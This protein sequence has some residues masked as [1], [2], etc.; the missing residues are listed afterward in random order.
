MDRKKYRKLL[1]F[2]SKSL[3]TIL[4]SLISVVMVLPFVWMIS[5]SLKQ[6]SEVFNYPI[7]WIPKKFDFSYHVAVWTG[8]DSLVRYYLNS[9]K[10][11]V[12]PVIAGLVICSMAAYSFSKLEY[13]GRNFIFMLYMAMLMIPQQILFVPKFLLFVPLGIYN[14]HWALILPHC[15]SITS[16]FLMRQS[17]MSIPNEFSEAAIIDGASHFRIWSQIIMPLS[18]PIIATVSILTFTWY[19]N[20][21]Q[22]ALIFISSKKLYTVPLILSRYVLDDRIDYSAMMAA[23]FAGIVPLILVFLFFQKFIIQGVASSGVKG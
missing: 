13:K 6:S 11:T 19:W 20:D 16:I 2:A 7:E 17:F 1:G 15:I 9:L 21:Y 3:S 5:T 12:I 23:A 18:K 8:P 22:N 4:L 10:T 14:T